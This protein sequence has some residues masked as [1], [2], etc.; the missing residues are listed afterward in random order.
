MKI[1]HINLQTPV[2][3]ISRKNVISF[4]KELDKQSA[5]SV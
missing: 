1:C 2:L 5:V 3:G 4:F